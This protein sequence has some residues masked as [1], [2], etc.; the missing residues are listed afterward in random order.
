VFGEPACSWI[1]AS[2][3]LGVS[4]STTNPTEVAASLVFVVQSPWEGSFTPNATLSPPA[5]TV[6]AGEVAVLD[7][8]EA[9]AD[10]GVED[11]AL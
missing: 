7:G 6:V 10:A 8:S 4:L 3:E 9:D 5:G 2:N 11:V 1:L